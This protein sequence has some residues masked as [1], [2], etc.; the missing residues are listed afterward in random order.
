[1]SIFTDQWVSITSIGVSPSQWVSLRSVDSWITIC[2]SLSISPISLV[3]QK[4]MVMVSGCEEVVGW[5]R[6]SVIGGG[7]GVRV[8]HGVG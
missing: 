6:W 8:G 1:M 2:F 5:V 3:K 7:G 4:S